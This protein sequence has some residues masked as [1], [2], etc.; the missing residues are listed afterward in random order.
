MEADGDAWRARDNVL[1]RFSSDG[2]AWRRI[3]IGYAVE[4]GDDTCPQAPP[5]RATSGAA[6]WSVWTRTTATGGPARIPTLVACWSAL[7][8]EF[9]VRVGGRDSAAHHLR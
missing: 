6:A 5:L 9:V 7:W 3:T 8:V 2:G 1:G 4:T